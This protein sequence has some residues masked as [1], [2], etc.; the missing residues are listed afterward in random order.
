MVIAAS[1]LAAQ[2]YSFKEYTVLDGLPQTQAR[3]L[4]Q[5]SRGFLWIITRIG[6]SRFD[7]IEFKN[8]LRKDGLPANIIGQIFEDSE[9]HIWA[10]STNG[11]SRY[12]GYAFKYFPYS[13]ELLYEGFR[14]A[15]NLNDTILL[16]LNNLND[17]DNKLIC[18]KDGEYFKYPAKNN[19]LDTISVISIN[20]DKAS[21]F[22]ILLDSYNNA[23]KWKNNELIPFR[24][25][26]INFV[27]NDR[28]KIVLEGE[29][30]NF[31]IFKML[32]RN[33]SQI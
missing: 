20:F 7:G 19:V 22:Y 31:E 2:N 18:F 16:V 28:G 13:D 23:W 32:S 33:K 5:D 29:E 25:I 15:I 8:F 26:K 17:S 12:D 9:G 11:I 14:C 4:Y 1:I 24:D 6:I 30:G 27:R 21:G 3:I 10:L